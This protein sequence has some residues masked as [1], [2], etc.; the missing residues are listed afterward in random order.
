LGK[1]PWATIALSFI[2]LLAAFLRFW[3]LDASEFKYD[4]ARVCNL[5]AHFVDT[6]IP[7]VRGM[8][9]SLGIDN[10]PL[11]IYLISLPVLISR[12]PLIATGFVAMLNVAAVGAC[13]WLGRRF[14][15]T[16]TGVV[17]STLLAVSP[18]AVFYA[19]KVWAQDLLLPFVIIFFACLLRWLLDGR[20]WALSGAVIALAALVQIHMAAV[21]LVP[22]LGLA[23][24]IA[25][26]QH[27]ARRKARTLWAP[28]LVGVA[29]SLLLYLPYLVFDALNGWGNLRGF[30]ARTGAPAQFYWQTVKFALLNVGGREIHALAGPERFR[31][32]LGDIL[33]LAYWPDR[34][35]EALVLASL[36]YLVIRLWRRRHDHAT[37]V[38]D[39][40]LVLWILTPVL[41]F[42]RSRS[43][44]FPHYLITLYPAPYLA[45]GAGATDLFK[46]IG[47]RPRLR[48]GAYA[49]G[50]LAL[51]ALIAWQSYLSLSI[52]AFVET[53]H[54]PGGIGTPIGTL[55]AV[56]R[57]AHKLADEFENLQ[58]VVLCPGD[59][60]AYDQCPA[61]LEFMAG[62][63]LDLRFMDQ[64]AGLLFP[65]SDADTLVVLAP[66]T[67]LPPGES[68][69]AS[70][71]PRHAQALPEH[72]IWLREAVGAYRF[73][74]IPAGYAPRPQ[75]QPSGAPAR[76][77]NGAVLIGYGLPALTSGQ[78]ATLVLYWRVD[79]PPVD[80]PAQGYSF[81][82]HVLGAGDRRYGQGDRPS[83]HVGRWRVGDTF[84][85]WFQVPLAAEAPPPPYRL[86]L[87]MY[88]Y[89]PP[90]QFAPVHVLDATGQPTA[91]YVD[92]SLQ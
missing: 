64:N 66:G 88:V 4:E 83:Y 53:H 33:D 9:S 17:A 49:L 24:L 57:S 63:T 12:D 35:E 91:E 25:F 89:T 58:V 28:L 21:A 40:V 56:A 15:N 22:L 16:G 70:A 84:E 37:L 32:F 18:W 30:L 7:P 61:V 65:Q 27:R 75:I 23:L 47:R 90:D 46:A 1:R 78:T 92:W 55:R 29:I 77:A 72:T 11:T 52:H 31:Q 10:P 6:G 71:L 87:G 62:R 13:Y 50:A 26:V 43:P 60:P 67:T 74:R 34:I 45:L 14:W 73:Y 76:F 86:R 51:T 2:L 68:T 48:R 19:R 8:G 38:R 41:F 36:V 79:A 5:A 3:N 20:R 81:A 39:G 42:L 54:T 44:T 85:S 80:P 82:V 69:A 59:N